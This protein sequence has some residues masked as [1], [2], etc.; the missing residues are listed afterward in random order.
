MRLIQGNEACAL[1]ALHAG[2][3]YYAGYPITP[4]SEIMEHMA[5]L[6]PARHGVFVQ[7]EDEIAAMAA[8]IGASWGG[9]KAMTATS[10]P[11]FSLMQENL[12]YASMTETPCVVVDS[13]RMG[14]STGLP[15]LPSQGDVMQARWGSHGDRVAIALTASSVRDVYEVTVACFNISEQYR[16]PVVL[17][18]DAVVS[19]MREGVEFPDL[20]VV[21]RQRPASLAEFLPF[22][23]PEFVPLGSGKPIVV[24]GLAHADTGL[25]RASDGANSERMMRRIVDRIEAAGDTIL[26]TRPVELDDAEVGIIAYGITARPARGAVNLLRRE[27]IRAGLLELQTIWPLPERAIRELASRTRLLLVPELNLGQLVIPIRAAVEGAAPVVPLNRIDGLVFTPEEIADSVRRSL[28]HGD[29]A[30]A[31]SLAEAH[32]A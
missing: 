30:A 26:R 20:P 15:T 28:A 13:Q 29:A 7:M 2:C 4:A 3:T 27:G 18:L 10:G 6:L 11:G 8:I 21:T 16:I 17:L 23:G 5:R 14:P 22:G 1:G 9:A 24:T 12:G 25:P 32:H 31:L 19:H